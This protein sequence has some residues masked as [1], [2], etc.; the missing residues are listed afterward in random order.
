MSVSTEFWDALAPQHAKLENSYLDRPSLRRILPLIETPVL[1]VGA[2]QGVLVAELRQKGLRC[3]G[4]DWSEEMIHYARKRRNLD[5]VRTDAK[6]MPFSKGAY[7]TLIYATGVIDFMTDEEEIGA[8]LNEGRRIAD[9]SGRIFVAFYRFSPAT[10]EL[11]TRLALL[12]GNAFRF[13]ETLEIYR[14]SAVQAIQ[15]T[16]RR[17]KV[18]F[19]R[20]L[21]WSVRSW[22][23]S[24]WQ[25]K[26]NAFHM[27]RTFADTE[28]ADALTRAAPKVQ[29]YRN[30]VE[31]KNLFGRLGIPMK[32]LERMSNCYVVEI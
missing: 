17:A 19:F 1:V 27:Q 12:K 16:A 15:W 26:R 9:A 30:E 8:I 7:Q 24:S 2:G 23:L 21:I 31:I 18:G 5:L 22:A 32:R 29:S 10:E 25:E 13:R 3:D 4:V 11:L 28:R 20:A 6:A 14:L